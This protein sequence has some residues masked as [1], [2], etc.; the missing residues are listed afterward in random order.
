MPQ[1]GSGSLIDW[2]LAVRAGKR[3]SPASPDVSRREADDA[4]DELYRATAQ[5][6]DVVA[7]LTHLH[8]PPVT[9]VTRVIDRPAWIETNAAGMRNVMAPV[10]ERLT[11]DNPVGKVAER[12]G[13]RLTGI[14]VGVVLG[15]LSG[16]VLGQFEFFERAGGQLLLVAPNLVAVERQLKV[17]PHDF[18][19][20]VCLHEVTHRVQFTA[21][22]WLRRHMLDEIDALSASIDTDPAEMR[23]RLSGAVGELVKVVRGQG[24][25]AG[26]LAVLATPEQRAVLERVTAFMSLVEGHAE[27]VMNA[28]SPTVIPSQ[29]VIENRFATRRRRGGNPLDRLLRRVLGMEAKTRQYID[30]SAFVR[31][32]VDRIGVDDFNA[33]WTSRETLPT[34]AEITDPELWIARVHA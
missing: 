24:N 33:I 31:T 32:V 29:Q 12:V 25:G 10:V 2:N 9:A 14:Q 6:A 13:G 28:V 18:R 4:V 22:P 19:L 30:G 1:D 34:R 26:V 15:F 20:W 8:E 3:F 5:A 11:E 23:R 17:D 7:E 21:V 27:Y 16:K